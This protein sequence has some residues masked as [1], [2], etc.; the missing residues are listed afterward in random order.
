MA[1]YWSLKYVARDERIDTD[2]DFVVAPKYGNSLKELI[3]HYPN[4][5]PQ[6]VICRALGITNEQYEKIYSSA[7]L[8]LRTFLMRNN[9]F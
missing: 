8:K 3:K 9:E 4:G 6:S 7:I 5:V 2:D 1:K